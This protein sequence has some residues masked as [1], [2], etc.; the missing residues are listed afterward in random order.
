MNNPTRPG[1]ELATR[2]LHFI[3]LA[4]C[5]SSMSGQKITAL[6]FAIREAIPAMRVVA[7]DN[8]NASV[9]VRAIRFGS[10]VQWHVAQ[11]TPLASFTWTDL[12]TDGVTNM[13]KALSMVA[14]QLKVPPMHER[15]LP[16]V[17][18]L[19]S[20]GQPTDDFNSGL[21]KLFDEKWGQKAVR[22]AI[23]IGDDADTDVLQRFIN[24]PE[25][26][27]LKASNSEDLVNY[28][29]WASTAVLQSASSPTAQN[30]SSPTPTIPQ[31]PPPTGS[32]TGPDVW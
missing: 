21:K 19:I 31:P 15:A 32:N 23:A 30:P 9:L 24:N 28:I 10:S 20:D 14:E 8:P 5:S 18:V 2:P 11:P 26:Q 7:H 6:N 27:P 22:I 16:P 13:G 29:K 4:D 25:I 1:R 12:T 3:W 17:L